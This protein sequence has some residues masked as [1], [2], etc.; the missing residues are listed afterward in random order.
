M[1]LGGTWIHIKGYVYTPKYERMEPENDGLVQTFFPLPMAL[2]CQVP[3]LNFRGICLPPL[4][5]LLVT[6]RMFL[7]RLWELL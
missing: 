4:A 6:T 7:L 1:F 5:R 2:N 3:Q